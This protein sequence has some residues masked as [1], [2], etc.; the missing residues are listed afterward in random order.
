MTKVVGYY[1]LEEVLIFWPYCSYNH[2]KIINLMFAL[3]GIISLFVTQLHSRWL[4][5]NL[6]DMTSQNRTCS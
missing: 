4:M 6:L 3:L 2:S 1:A 5:L